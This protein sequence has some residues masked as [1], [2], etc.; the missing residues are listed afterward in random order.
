MRETVRHER[1]AAVLCSPQ[2]LGGDSG[3]GALSEKL[4]S[5]GGSAAAGENRTGNTYNNFCGGA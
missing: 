2:I 4:F 3:Y 5:T 1:R